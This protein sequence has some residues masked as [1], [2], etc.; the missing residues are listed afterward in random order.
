MGWHPAVHGTAAGRGE[1]RAAPVRPPLSPA[2]G[3]EGPTAPVPLG[4][5]RPVP[6][7]RV[8]VHGMREEG[9]RTVVGTLAIALE[10]AALLKA[11]A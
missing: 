9:M 4:A 1:P 5:P 2:G 8:T 6:I 11:L 3:P 7:A 10:S